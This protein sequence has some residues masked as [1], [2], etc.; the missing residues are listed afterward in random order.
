MQGTCPS[1]SLQVAGAQQSFTACQTLSGIAYPFQLLWT[2]QE[3]GSSPIAGSGNDSIVVAGI[4]AVY[5]GW[6][7]SPLY[8]RLTPSS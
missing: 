5:N 4:T 3:P 1:L 6:A 2:L 7:G 8:A